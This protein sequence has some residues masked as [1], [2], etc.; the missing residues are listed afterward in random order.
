MHLVLDQAFLVQAVA[1]VIVYV[2]DLD[3][4]PKE[5]LPT[6]VVS[7]Y[8]DFHFYPPVLPGERVADSFKSIVEGG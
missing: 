4:A 7:C 1:W 3:T 6:Q 5:P 8:T 2:L